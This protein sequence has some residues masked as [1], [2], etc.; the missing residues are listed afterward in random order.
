MKFRL[1][2]IALTS[3]DAL[4]KVLT[5]LDLLFRLNI[6]WHLKKNNFKPL[7]EGEEKFYCEL[8]SEKDDKRMT[9]EVTTF[10]DFKNKTLEMEVKNGGKRKFY[11]KISDVD[12]NKSKIEFEEERETEIDEKDKIRLNLWVK[13]IINY[14][15]LSESRSIFSRIWKG[16]LDR[17]YLKLSPTGRRIVFLV[18]ISEIFA[19]L[20]FIVLL[21]FYLYSG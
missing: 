5:N 17:V 11:F 1:S 16:F 20:F 7:S 3:S 18:V 8:V 15:S 6:E 21:L 9:C 2:F 14:A 19:L 12:R 13:S 10:T 4:W